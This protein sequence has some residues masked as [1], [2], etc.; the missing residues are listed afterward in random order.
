MEEIEE[1]PQ[2][3]KYPSTFTPWRLILLSVSR[4][5]TRHHFSSI[6]TL[7]LKGETSTIHTSSL[8]T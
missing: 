8:Y 1:A 5:V 3:R 7:H 2:V 6:C 4:D